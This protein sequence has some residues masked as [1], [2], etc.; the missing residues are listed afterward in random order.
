[1]A[2]KQITSLALAKQTQEGVLKQIKQ[3]QDKGEL[4]VPQNYS[5]E[6]AL[7]AAWLKIQQTTDRNGK[8][9]ID[10]CTQVSIANAMLTTVVQGL[11]PDKAQVYYI[12]YGDKLVAQRSYFGAE[13]VAKMVNEN[14][15][16]FSAQPIYEGDEIDYE[17]KDGKKYIKSHKQKFQDI[18][19]ANIIGVYCIVKQQDGD[20]YA[21]I[22]TMAEIQEA[23]KKSPTKPF[24]DNGNLKPAST[25]AQYT[26]EM[27][28]KTVIGRTC[29]HIINSSDDHNIVT[30]YAIENDNDIA[31]AT[32]EIE[33]EEN[34]NTG[35]KI[36]VDFSVIDEETGEVQ[37]NAVDESEVKA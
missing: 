33:I 26:A 29:K 27:A 22:M 12:V 4:V 31:K 34:A 10:V 25:H 6:N 17:I 37:E 15:I 2:E 19:K 18:N 3:F 5:P 16:D 32:A 11:N 23:W 7:K 21:I 20:N 9:A 13:C 14:V 8:P 24:D 28:C 35:D 1:M 30:K 36:E